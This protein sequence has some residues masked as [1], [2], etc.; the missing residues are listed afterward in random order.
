[1]ATILTN[2]MEIY[3]SSITATSSIPATMTS[4]VAMDRLR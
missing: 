3:F 2:L 1:M 4:S